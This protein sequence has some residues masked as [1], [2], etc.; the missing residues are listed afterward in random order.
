MLADVGELVD[1]VEGGFL[2][3]ASEGELNQSVE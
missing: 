3:E 1:E 2:A